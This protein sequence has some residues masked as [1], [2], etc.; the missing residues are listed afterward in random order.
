[1][2][3]LVQ[4]ATNSCRLLI[5]VDNKKASVWS[6]LSITNFK[7]ISYRQQNSFP[8]EKENYIFLACEK[9]VDNYAFQSM[10]VASGFSH[11]Q[12]QRTLVTKLWHKNI[13]S[14]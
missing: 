11:W 10:F 14:R 6:K 1:M 7:K 9:V 12:A 5:V 13:S 4:S 3:D 8:F 2:R